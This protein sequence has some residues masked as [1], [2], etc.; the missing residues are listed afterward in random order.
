MDSQEERVFFNFLTNEDVSSKR[1][2]AEFFELVRSHLD[3]ATLGKYGVHEPLRSR[4]GDADGAALDGPAD[5]WEQNVFWQSPEGYGCA[6]HAP[7]WHTWVRMYFKSDNVAHSSNWVCFLQE[8][9]TLLRVDHSSCHY[10][11]GEPHTKSD[12]TLQGLTSHHLKVG[13]PTLAWASCFGKPFTDLWGVDRLSEAPFECVEALPGG[14]LYC[15]LTESP[16]D[17]NTNPE[18][19]ARRQERVTEFL[20]PEHF[21]GS[22]GPERAEVVPEFVPQARR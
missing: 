7:H 12:E 21:W 11:A 4:L 1:H 3:G 19:F 8:A 15:Q 5:A 14:Q 9:S 6:A 13:L 18:G 20:G 17:Y 2:G 22:R 10:F 16:A